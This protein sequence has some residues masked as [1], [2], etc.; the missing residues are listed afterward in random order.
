[1]RGIGISR[2]TDPI[3]AVGNCGPVISGVGQ[4]AWGSEGSGVMFH[5]GSHGRMGFCPPARPVPSFQEADRH[6][7]ANRSGRQGAQAFPKSTGAMQ[8]IVFSV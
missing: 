8:Y 2:S 4:S 6:K 1:M 3:P 5:V 7:Q